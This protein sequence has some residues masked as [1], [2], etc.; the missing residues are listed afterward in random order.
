MYSR[1]AWFLAVAGW[2]WIAGDQWYEALSG[3]FTV[4]KAV[5]VV[6]A[7]LL[8]VF[9]LL[10]FVVNRAW[11]KRSHEKGTNNVGEKEIIK[12]ERS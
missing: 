9:F 8:A 3:G 10:A 12:R 7:T 4:A 5:Q 6:L 2:I 1:V 11:K